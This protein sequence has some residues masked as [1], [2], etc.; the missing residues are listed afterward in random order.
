[1]L[2]HHRSLLAVEVQRAALRVLF[3]NFREDRVGFGD[4]RLAVEQFGQEDEALFPGGCVQVPREARTLRV[5]RFP[6][7]FPF[8]KRARKIAG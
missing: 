6:D 8:G 5:F 3:F 2:L 4:A 1:L 7:P